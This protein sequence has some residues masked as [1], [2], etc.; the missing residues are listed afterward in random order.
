MRN[1]TSLF[2]RLLAARVFATCL[3]TSIWFAV[4]AQGQIPLNLEPT[5]V[6]GHRQLQLV[7]TSPNLV[8]ARDLSAPFG[9]A[10]DSST[11]PPILYVSD[12]GNYRVLGWRN[13]TGFS[14]G[15]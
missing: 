3:A 14:N 11:T 1:T 2:P 8:E 7:T 13:L 6:V 12:F 9:I 4:V 10:I 15:D 5:R